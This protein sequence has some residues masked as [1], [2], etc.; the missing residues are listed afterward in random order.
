MKRRHRAGSDLLMR[1]A[2]LVVV[3]LLSACLQ[4]EALHRARA[5]PEAASA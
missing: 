1:W 5:L 4:L 3:G 2:G